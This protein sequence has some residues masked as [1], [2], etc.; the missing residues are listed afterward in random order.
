MSRLLSKYITV[1]NNFVFEGEI[2]E[3]GDTQ[4]GTSLSGKEWMKVRYIIRED[5]Q[6]HPK[7]MVFDIFGEETLRRYCLKKGEYVRLTFRMDTKKFKEKVYNVVTILG[8][9]RIERPL[10]EASKPEKK[11]TVVKEHLPWES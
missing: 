7:E 4:T 6:N 3:Q 2:I 8:V 5:G 9:E 11:H 10:A 1:M